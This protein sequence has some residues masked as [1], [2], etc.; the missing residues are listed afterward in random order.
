MS[1][2]LPEDQALSRVTD[3]LFNELAYASENRM[4]L[5]K[6]WKVASEEDMAEAG[7]SDSETDD[8]GPILRAPDGRLFEVEVDVNLSLLRRDG[9]A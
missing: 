9:A 2:L 5:P 7:W 6:D 3:F 4:H 1:G 8:M